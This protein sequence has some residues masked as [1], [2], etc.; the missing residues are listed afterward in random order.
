MGESEPVCESVGERVAE[1]EGVEEDDTEGEGRRA[2]ASS[3]R[4]AAKRPASINSSSSPA[5]KPAVMATV[6]E[7]RKSSSGSATVRPGQ[8]FTGAPPA[9]KVRSGGAPA[10]SKSAGAS[11]TAVTLSRHTAGTS[12]ARCADL[13][14]PSL[15]AR[16]QTRT[17]TR[18]VSTRGRPPVAR[19]A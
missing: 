12:V 11:F 3:R 18:R 10:G 8:R 1:K 19:L 4:M 16:S 2:K 5:A 14:P 15:A 6:A 17:S 13:A 7:A 9:T